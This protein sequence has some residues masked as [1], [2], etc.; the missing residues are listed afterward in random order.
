MFGV[1]RLPAEGAALRG[2][3]QGAITAWQYADATDTDRLR[4][5]PGKPGR[6][7]TEVRQAG[8]LVGRAETT[9]DSAGVPLTARLIVPSVPAK[10]DLTFL[11]TARADFA[12]D[13][14]TPRKP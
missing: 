1:A 5:D 14:W 9:L 12:P 4:A 13:I 6:L 10:L 3:T 2:L 8:E 11:S 7:V